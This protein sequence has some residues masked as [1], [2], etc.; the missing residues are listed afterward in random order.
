M[1]LGLATTDLASFA[2][3]LLMKLHALSIAKKQIFGR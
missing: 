1:F 2:P 3:K